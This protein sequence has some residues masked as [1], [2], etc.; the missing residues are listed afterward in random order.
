RHA[1]P[2]ALPSFPTRRSS[3]LVLSASP[4]P[5]DAAS[6]AVVV[7]GSVV[8]VR[9]GE[10]PSGSSDATILA[11]R[12]EFES[13]QVVVEAGSSHDHGGRRSEEHTSEL[14]SR[15]HLVCRR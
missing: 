10:H 9:P 15:G 6:A 3:D 2:C 5:A 14:Q 4:P 8:K 12:N 1:T 7:V 11:A 13:F